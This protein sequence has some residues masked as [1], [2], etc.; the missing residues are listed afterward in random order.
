[1]PGAREQEA[2]DRGAAVVDLNMGCP[3]DK[4]TKKDGGSK[5]LCDPDRTLGL[6][7]LALVFRYVRRGWRR[8]NRERRAPA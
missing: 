5:L 8:W 7:L 1:M 4:V 6:V 3:V 2:E